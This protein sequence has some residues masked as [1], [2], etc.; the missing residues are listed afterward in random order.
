M[1][2]WH[3]AL[4]EENGYDLLGEITQSLVD[5]DRLE[6][7]DDDRVFDAVSATPSYFWDRFIT[8]A[9]DRM[10]DAL[11]Q[12]FIEVDASEACEHN[13]ESAHDDGIRCDDCGELMV[14]NPDFT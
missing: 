7:Y 2:A 5:S 6:Q 1:N 10:A 8:P 4:F 3:K 12:G 14:D 9:L 11:D 13:N